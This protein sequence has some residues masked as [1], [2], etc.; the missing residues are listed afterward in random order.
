MT[1]LTASKREF[2]EME[3]VCGKRLS[4]WKFGVARGALRWG[5]K[6]RGQDG[7]GRAFSM[8]SG[9]RVAIQSFANAPELMRAGRGLDR[10]W[11]TSA[12]SIWQAPRDRIRKG[13]VP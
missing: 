9:T 7:V 6:R 11:V 4:R 3:G 13:L 5:F 2:V 12:E 8:G 1:P 10:N